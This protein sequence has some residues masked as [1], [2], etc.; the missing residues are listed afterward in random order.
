MVEPSALDAVRSSLHVSA[1]LNDGVETFWNVELWTFPQPTAL[2]L[3]PLLPA[4][5]KGHQRGTSGWL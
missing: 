4:L 3:P 2:S 5:L 1:V